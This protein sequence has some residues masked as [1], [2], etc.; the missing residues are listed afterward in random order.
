VR[1]LRRPTMVT[2]DEALPGRD[3]P[4]EL[5]ATHHVL[6]RPM[7]PPFPE[8]SRLLVVGMGCFWGAERLLWQL[9]GAWT[10]WV[11]YAGGFTPNPTYREVCTGRTGHAEVAALVYDP[12]ELDLDTVLGAFW[13]NHD[14][15]QVDGQGN[16][17]GTQYRSVVFV[18]DDAE[19]TAVEA[20]RDRYQAKLHAEGYGDIATT[21][22]ELGEVYPAEPEHQQ[23]LAKNPGGYCNHGFCQVAY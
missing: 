7:A 21:L 16:D 5:P 2:P 23:Y 15:T 3:T 18:A 1:F 9:P 10:T 4:I 13:E 19:R 12:A 6:G 22:E 17:I 14:P 8:G 20:S 11:G